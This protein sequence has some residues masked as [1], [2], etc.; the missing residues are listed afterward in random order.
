T[1]TMSLP[2]LFR[3][4]RHVH[5]ACQL[6]AVE[7]S[8]L[9]KLRKSTGYTFINCKKA[10][11][12]FDNDINQG[13]GL[14]HAGPPPGQQPGQ[15][16]I[17]EGRERQEPF[18]KCGLVANVCSFTREYGTVCDSADSVSRNVLHRPPRVSWGP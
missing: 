10:L 5:T 17:R 16:G 12:K 8:L 18:G 13:R 15:D 11:E 14:C 7:K 3:T 6:L 1:L 2:M 4:G 9:M